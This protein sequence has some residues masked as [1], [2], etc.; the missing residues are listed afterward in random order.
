M[1]DAFGH[2]DDCHLC[3]G[4]TNIVKNIIAVL[5]LLVWGGWGRGKLQRHIYFA[6]LNIFTISL[7]SILKRKVPGKFIKLISKA[8]HFS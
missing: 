3:S 1:G 8:L 2:A 4:N 6:F 5:Y 7:D